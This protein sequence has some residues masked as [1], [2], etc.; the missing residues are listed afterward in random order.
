MLLESDDERVEC[1]NESD[2]E[3]EGYME[4]HLEDFNTK[5]DISSVKKVK[6]KWTWM[7]SIFWK[8]RI[9]NQNGGKIQ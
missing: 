7:K 1:E 4:V 3:D 6:M 8:E 9:K 2:L 5:Q